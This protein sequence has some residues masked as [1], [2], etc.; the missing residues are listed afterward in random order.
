MGDTVNAGDAFIALGNELIDNGLYFITRN[1]EATLISTRIPLRDLIVVTNSQILITIPLQFEVDHFVP[2]PT[3]EDIESWFT[4]T[5]MAVKINEAIEVL[6]SYA[7]DYYRA[8]AMLN[9]PMDELLPPFKGHFFVSGFRHFS[10]FD[11]RTF[12][13][14]SDCGSTHVL[15]ADM[16]TGNFSVS[17]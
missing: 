8:R 12:D 9:I 13:Y 16:K 5:A 6:F 17:L 3:L 7:D 14:V 1:G 4:Q 15:G 10:T 2:F 11:Q